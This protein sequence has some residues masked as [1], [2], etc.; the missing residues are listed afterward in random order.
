[1]TEMCFDTVA[2]GEL[3]FDGPN[4][5]AD[6]VIIDQRQQKIVL[7]QRKTGEWALPGG[8]VDPGD[9]D[10][11]SAARR[12]VS[13]EASLDMT[14]EGQLIFNGVV[15]DPRNTERAW[16]ETS[17]YLFNG[18][19]SA[20]VAA[21]DDAQNAQWHDI[22]NLPQ[23]YA[24]HQHILNLALDRI[25][26]Q[27]LADQSLEYARPAA[28]GHMEYGKYIIDS[29]SP[30][31]VKAHE[32]ERYTDANKAQKSLQYLQKEAA[33]MSH[34]RTHDFP[35]L[36]P[37]SILNN[38]RLVMNAMRP[39]DGWHWK[40]PEHDLDKYTK[41]CIDA[42]QSLEEMPLPYNY[43]NIEASIES[44]RREGWDS[45]DSPEAYAK[46]VDRYTASRPH[47]DDTYNSIALTMLD[48]IPQLYHDHIQPRPLPQFV[49]SHHDIRQSNIAWHPE[50]GA[51]FVDWSWSGVG[52]KGSDTTSLL[53]D[54]HKGG[55]DVTPYLDSFNPHHAR[56]LIGFWLGHSIWPEHSGSI[57]RF[58][59]FVSTVAA[60]DLL[61]KST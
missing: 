25:A 32:A 54:L 23:L 26:N 29:D 39:E 50:H 35:H 19:S 33:T 27:H 3:W 9:I 16:I 30:M 60:F 52:E 2:P 38:G 58:Q 46:I 10:A 53:I 20:P 15:D 55:F 42:L 40:A 24:S 14:D 56:T 34:L 48:E 12:E 7:I 61:K 41:D 1:M 51:R 37:H 43:F 31:F 11:S 47:L 5:T 8:F 57:V 21:A 17:A 28:G 18:D 36:P 59:Q 49:H 44:M 45:L 4:Y 13:E 22:S 6:A